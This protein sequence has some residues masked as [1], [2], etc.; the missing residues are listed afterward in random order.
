MLLK[1]LILATYCMQETG[2]KR[3]IIELTVPDSTVVRKMMVMV[4]RVRVKNSD[5]ND[6]GGGGG[7]GGGGEGV[8]D[9]RGCRRRWCW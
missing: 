9:V 5:D 6:S 8:D 7:G 4:I 2:C 3:N 1:L